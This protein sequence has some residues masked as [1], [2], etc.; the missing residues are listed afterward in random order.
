MVL[1]VTQSLPQ[2]SGF[3]IVAPPPPPPRTFSI[4]GEL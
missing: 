3:L 1:D 2:L 4:E